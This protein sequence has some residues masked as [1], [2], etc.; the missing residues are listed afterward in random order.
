MKKKLHSAFGLSAVAIVCALAVASCGGG[1]LERNDFRSLD[2]TPPISLGPNSPA[3][4]PQEL[5]PVVDGGADFNCV[6]ASPVAKQKITLVSSSVDGQG[7]GGGI[8]PIGNSDIVYEFDG[9]SGFTV[10]SSNEY[11]YVASPK[12]ATYS[13]NTNVVNEVFPVFVM[14]AE[15]DE[16]GPLSTIT[17]SPS[18]WMQRAAKHPDLAV[19]GGTYVTRVNLKANGK[20]PLILATI[21]YLQDDL[22]PEELEARRDPENDAIQVAFTATIKRLENSDVDGVQSAC[23]YSVELTRPNIGQ[24]EDNALASFE[25]LG[26]GLG[27][28]YDDLTQRLF[29]E[30][31]MPKISGTFSTSSQVPF[32]PVRSE[33]THVYGVSSLA[34]EVDVTTDKGNTSPAK[35][36]TPASPAASQVIKF[37]S[38][39]ILP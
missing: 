20:L 23:N 39:E 21:T 2:K 36:L 1:E 11:A 29:L 14:P 31:Y 13:T 9:A 10:S 22:T 7:E 18:D 16:R 17:Y 24:S 12:A 3:P 4:S 26:R 33:L 30:P 38:A 34:V 35:A 19:V 5:D 28:V 25:L 32:V 27:P 15:D 37:V 6:P 8:Y